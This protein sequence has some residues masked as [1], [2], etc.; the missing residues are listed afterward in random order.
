M[1]IGTV[2]IG[3][4]YINSR[5]DGIY[6]CLANKTISHTS[7]STALEGILIKIKGFSDVYDDIEVNEKF[8]LN[9]IMTLV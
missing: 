8:E 3:I 5:T 6:F 9:Y 4:V 2:E 1:F 7:I